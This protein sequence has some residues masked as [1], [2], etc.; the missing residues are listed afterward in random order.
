MA[1][2]VHSINSTLSGTCYHADVLADEEH[3][4]Y[5]TEL[6]A[7]AQ[8]LILGRRTYDLFAEFWPSALQRSDLPDFVVRLA[9]V[10]AATP[11]LVV[12]NR[13]FRTSWANT[14]RIHGPELSGLRAALSA[15]S[16]NVV[17]FGSPSL[18][19]SLAAAGL[20][21]E[22]HVLLQ[23]LFSTQGPQIPQLWEDAR[24]RNVSATRFKSGVVLLRYVAE[25]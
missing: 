16:A 17:L 6:L 1:R 22:V 9:T 2:I 14:R 3:H 23:P 13:E 4:Q 8:A 11:K 12:S 7:S 19:S 18:A 20:L 24:L 21:D 15:Y 10:L 25:A 5:A